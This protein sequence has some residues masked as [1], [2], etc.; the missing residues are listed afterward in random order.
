MVSVFLTTKFKWKSFDSNWMRVVPVFPGLLANQVAMNSDWLAS[1]IDADE[2]CLKSQF[3]AGLMLEYDCRSGAGSKGDS[4]AAFHCY[5]LAANQGHSD[6]M[7]HVAKCIRESFGTEYCLK[8]YIF[9]LEAVVLKGS[10]KYY[11]NAKCDLG[12]VYKSRVKDYTAAYYWFAEAAKDIKTQQ[13]WFVM[14]IAA[15]LGSCFEGGYGVGK[16]AVEAFKWHTIAALASHRE[17]QLKVGTWHHERKEMEEAAKFYELGANSGN[18]V[19]QYRFAQLLERGEGIGK[20]MAEAFEWYRE[21]A[22]QRGNYEAKCRLGQI[23]LHGIGGITRDIKSGLHYIRWASEARVPMAQY[24]LD[25]VNSAMEL[26]SA[27]ADSGIPEAKLRLG[28]LWIEQAAEEDALP[29][30]QFLLGCSFK[31]GFGCI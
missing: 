26:I 15:E 28:K 18:K 23:L 8:S 16:N 6:A 25:Y 30:A 20:D 17:S 21:A 11:C 9:W 22:S 14:N 5:Q 27:A 19:A 10:S 13:E 4:I 31:F 24:E 7:Y 12:D 1:G 29:E 2:G 3:I